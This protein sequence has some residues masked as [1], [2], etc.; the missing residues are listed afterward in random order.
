M[1]EVEIKLPI[2]DNAHVA[3]K[4]LQLQFVKTGHVC[5]EDVYFD[6]ESQQIRTNG[7]ALRIRKITDL[8]AETSETVITFKGKKID[9]VSMSRRELETSVGDKNVCEGI[10][11]ALGYYPV[12]PRVITDRQEFARGRMHA[13][14]DRVKD[15][16]VFLELEIV[17]D[18]AESKDT[19]LQQ[20]EDVLTTLGYALADT[21]RNYYLSMLQ[22][23]E[24][25]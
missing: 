7:D 24:D 21:T 3:D 9:T 12:E 13:C 15:L 14:L 20:I 6:N 16:G 10:L 19:A 2:A 5:E 8:H 4:L 1:V 25:D 11:E 17:I 22:Q 18:E 23:V